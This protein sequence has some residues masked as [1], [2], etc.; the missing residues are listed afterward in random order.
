MNRIIS[1]IISLSMYN[2]IQTKPYQNYANLDSNRDNHLSRYE[3]IS[4][5]RKS[6]YFLRWS[7]GQNLNEPA[8]YDSIYHKINISGD[9]GLISEEFE[10]KIN[11]YYL[12]RRSETFN[13]W[14]DDNSHTIDRS[15]FIDHAGRSALFTRWDRSGDGRI[16][17]R[18][19]ADGMFYLCD[20]DGDGSI[21]SI[22]FNIWKVNR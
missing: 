5:Y 9:H 15:E 19:M 3:F 20:L 10:R 6:K 1:M 21:T 4:G 8:F 12:D 7:N 16:S 11:Y 14:D 13:H 17:E 22:E 2:C 18:E